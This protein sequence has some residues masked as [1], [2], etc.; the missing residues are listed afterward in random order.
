[1]QGIWCEIRGFSMSNPSILHDFFEPSQLV[2]Y[3]QSAQVLRS[4]FG[5]CD[6]E[7]Q[8]RI[9]RRNLVSALGTGRQG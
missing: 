7:G 1:M 5:V 9:H 8:G 4:I 3:L 2:V 6:V